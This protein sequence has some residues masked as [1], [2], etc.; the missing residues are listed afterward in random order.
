MITDA[1][2]EACARAL[3]NPTIE[4]VGHLRTLC[5]TDDRME[6]VIAYTSMLRMGVAG[7]VS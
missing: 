3:D 4:T 7:G 5:V 6:T 1:E 2:V